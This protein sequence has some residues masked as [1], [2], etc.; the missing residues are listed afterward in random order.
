MYDM[1][2]VVGRYA[3][4]KAGRDK[5]KVLIIV[6]VADENHVLVCD[7]KLRRIE[8]PKKKKLMHLNISDNFAGMI[9]EKIENGENVV[10]SEIRKSISDLNL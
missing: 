3:T 10:N 8:K 6:G 1:E 5:G 4:S 9:K 7:G 2:N